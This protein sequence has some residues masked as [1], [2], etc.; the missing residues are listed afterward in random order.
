MT[1]ADHST[2]QQRRG[3]QACSWGAAAEKQVAQWYERRGATVLA[4][5]QRTPYGEIDLV[6]RHNDMI[7]F[8][9]VK[10]R[11]HLERALDAVSA[12]QLGRLCAAIT[13]LLASDVF[14]GQ[15]C[16]LDLAGVDRQGQI[17]VVENISL[18]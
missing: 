9:E 16:R 7:V 8:V 14:Q 15:E 13:H 11:R 6:V 12:T 17:S 18:A 2:R 4:R 10:A 5:R 1:E 3:R